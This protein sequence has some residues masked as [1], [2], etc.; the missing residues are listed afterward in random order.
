MTKEKEEINISKCT[1]LSNNFLEIFN[2]YAS[3][4]LK[5]P[6]TKKRYEYV[7]FRICN[8]A[9]CDFL[10][11]TKEQVEAY[12]KSTNRNEVLK[13]TNYDL[14]VIR[15]IFRYLDDN[16]DFYHIRSGYLSL[17]S[18]IDVVF[19]DMHF[20]LEDIP[21]LSDVDCVLK[22]FKKENDFVGFIACSLVLRTAMTISQMTELKKDMFF[23]DLNLN[24]G[25]RIKVSKFAYRF[26][27][28]PDDIAELILLYME[29]RR[30]DNP[31]LLLNKKG[32][33]I[34][35]KALQNRLQDAC[36]NCD[37]KPFTFNKLRTLS[38]AYM[39]KSKAS[40]SQVAEY[41]NTKKTDW[42]FRYDRV[43]KELEDSAVDYVHIKVVW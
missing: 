36:L 7:I 37:I 39:I 1:Y 8:F 3:E 4:K 2:D 17:L 10:N 12:L 15:A 24:Y 11:L 35:I 43:V 16:A 26:I 31:A 21:S 18:D 42:F 22:Y 28:I 30:D 6:R 25:V 19:P 40:L 34:S 9:E 29:Q 32:K 13:S 20:K 5:K 23:K 14:S 38:E 33:P 27:K 41:T